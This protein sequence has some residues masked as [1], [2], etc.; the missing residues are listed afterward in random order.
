MER[1]LSQEEGKWSTEAAPSFST[2]AVTRL[3]PV[4]LDGSLEGPLGTVRRWVD[5]PRH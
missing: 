1:D 3:R 2:A 5:N 4:G